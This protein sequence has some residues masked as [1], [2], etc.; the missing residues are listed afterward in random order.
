MHPGLTSVD[1]R[2][3]FEVNINLVRPGAREHLV[4]HPRHQRGVFF[5]GPFPQQLGVGG[6]MRLAQSKSRWHTPVMRREVMTCTPVIWRETM[7][8][9]KLM[10]INLLFFSADPIVEISLKLYHD[11]I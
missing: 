11:D 4:S 5:K 6:T 2:A 3:D 1:R 10:K 9:C 8:G 7:E